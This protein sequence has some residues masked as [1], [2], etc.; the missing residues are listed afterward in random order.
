MP[1]PESQNA[2]PAVPAGEPALSD[3]TAEPALS[4]ATVGQP[5]MAATHAATDKAAN[6]APAG[7]TASATQGATAAPTPAYE[8][9]IDILVPTYNGG[10]LWRESAHAIARCRVASEHLLDV[11][12]VDSSSEDDSAKVGR[13]CGFRVYVIPPEEFDHGGTRNHALDLCDPTPDIAVFLTQ[14]AILATPDAIDILVRVFRDPAVAVA[15]GRQLP[16]T[17][18]NPIAAHARRFNYGTQGYIASQ[19]DAPKRGLKTVFNSNSFAAYRVS[20]LRELGG[21]PEK[22]ILSED[23]HLAARAVLA[24]YKVAYVP[25]ATAYHSHN[26]TATEEFRRYFDIGVFHRDHP[27]INE[28]FGGAGG[29]GRRFLVSEFF[30]LLTR[31][32]WWLPAAALH[33]LAKIVGYKLG[34]NYTRLPEKW[35]PAFSMNPRHWG[36]KRRPTKWWD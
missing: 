33:N 5:A 16:H 21:F 32:P 3:A 20:A 34:K 25:E 14:D 22:T 29:E 13:H 31:A 27:W 1:S 2:R 26:Y 28:K 8:P 24:G 30:Y 15:Y 19:A 11:M 7:G 10:R 23:M 4:D 6:P 17:N 36:A 18:A 9:M 35:R 12:V